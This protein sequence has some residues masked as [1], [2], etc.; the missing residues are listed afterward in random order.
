MSHQGS[1]ESKAISGSFVGIVLVVNFFLIALIIYAVNPPVTPNDSLPPLVDDATSV[2]AV[3][4]VE[5]M[6]EATE[7]SVEET[8]AV[9][10]DITQSIAF[11]A[12]NGERLFSMT[13]TACHG[14][15]ADGI[16]GLGPSMRNNVFINSL[17]NA[18]LA[19]FIKVGRSATVPENKTGI[20][21][22][23]RGGNPALSD[24]DIDTIVIY[25]RSLNPD[26][27]A[28][29]TSTIS[30]SPSTVPS[31]AATSDDPSVVREAT[32]FTPVD[33]TGIT[34]E[35]ESQGS[36]NDDAS[37]FF[38]RA[39]NVYS[40]SCAGCH[41]LDGAG[42]E[43]L[44]YSLADSHLLQQ[45]DGIALFEMFTSEMPPADPR[46]GF[47]HPYRGGYPE[48]DNESILGLIAYLYELSAVNL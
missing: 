35:R 41:G 34:A 6:A 10:E 14:F 3:E 32:V 11:R 4:E 8:E 31:S 43:L 13:C 47:V 26:V 36:A 9:V 2:A 33:L 37:A 12:I 15:S 16:S 45:R 7:E 30:I 40:F 19:E 44:H 42:T 24:D 27:V 21:M 46:E 18:D 22:P 1:G 38:R 29:E 48:L 28:P 17:S 20:T 39:E 23:A 25:I 5:P